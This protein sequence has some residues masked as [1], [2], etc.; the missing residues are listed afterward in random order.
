MNVFQPL[1]TVGKSS[2]FNVAGLL[3]LSLDCDE[4]PLEHVK[5]SRLV[6]AKKDN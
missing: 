5:A 1:N 2:F 6:A 3:D 4:F